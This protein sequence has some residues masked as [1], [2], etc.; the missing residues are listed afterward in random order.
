MPR[1]GS[2]P[3]EGEGPATAGR[4]VLR[5]SSRIAFS[6]SV[7][8]LTRPPPAQSPPETGGGDPRGQR[9][10]QGDPPTRGATR[11]RRGGALLGG[12]KAV[13]SLEAPPL[14]P[15]GG[16]RLQGPGRRPLPGAERVTN[17][18]SEG[19]KGRLPA[20]SPRGGPGGNVAPGLGAPRLGPAA[21]QPGTP[22][23]AGSGERRAPRARLRPASHPRHVVGSGRPSWRE[24]RDPR[25]RGLWEGH[26]STQVSCAGGHAPCGGAAHAPRIVHR[27]VTLGRACVLSR[28]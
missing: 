20:P 19:A 14:G 16:R 3:W 2:S 17:S 5:P 10:K 15:L 18:N 23:P 12:L 4:W 21:A 28:R 24:G 6:S 27:G 9:V 26:A 22:R 13:A 7:A 25:A 8:A 11:A 1:P